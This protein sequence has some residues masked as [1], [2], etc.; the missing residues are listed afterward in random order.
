[1]R[2]NLIIAL[3]TVLCVQLAPLSPLASTAQAASC[4]NEQSLLGIR[5]W[6]HGLCNDEGTGVEITNPG[7]DAVVIV[8][9]VIG[10]ALGVA[11]YVAVGFV[12]WGGIR[13]VIANGDS[14]KLSSAK[15]TIQNALIGLLI[16]LSAVAI[17]T[18]IGGI[19][20]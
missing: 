18:F 11:S 19:Y 20:T 9:N 13:Y 15:A 12:I 16:A 2:K 8:L 17:V 6:Y 1:M 7:K 10:I 4:K 5:P 14:G 3:L